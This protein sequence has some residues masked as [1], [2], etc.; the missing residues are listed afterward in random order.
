MSSLS[1]RIISTLAILVVACVQVFGM[2]HR[3]ACSHQ[4]SV[5]ETVAEHCHQSF[6]NDHTN[7]IPCELDS[8]QECDNK[9]EEEHHTPLKVD[10]QAAPS[11]SGVVSIPTFVA[12]LV[13]EVP[14][15]DWVMIQTLA[16][17]ELVEIPLESLGE[18]LSAALLVTECVVLLV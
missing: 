4:G 12:V 10:M 14:F 11:S 18:S 17:N 6:V 1:K 3:Y 5:V 2:Q 15:H 9:G 13:A 16:E 7:E 8:T